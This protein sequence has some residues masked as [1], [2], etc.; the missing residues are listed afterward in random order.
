MYHLLTHLLTTHPLLTY[1]VATASSTRRIYLLTTYL[2]THFLPGSYALEYTALPGAWVL[3][4]LVGSG[5][6]PPSPMVIVNVRL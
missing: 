3:S 4:V 6:V 5:L 2:P 1:Q